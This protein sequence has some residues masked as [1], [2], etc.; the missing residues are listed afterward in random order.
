MILPKKPSLIGLINIGANCFMN[1]TLQ[2]LAQIKKL[3][4]YFKEDKQVNQTIE[5]YKQ[6]EKDC[7]TES[8]KILIDNLWPEN[9]ENHPN[10][11]NN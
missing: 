1:A 5:I 11:K 8:F 3:I 4:I 2:C 10:N 7:L 6:N 9:Y